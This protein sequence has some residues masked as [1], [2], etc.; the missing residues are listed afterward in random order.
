MKTPRVLI[1]D[2]DLALQGLM[3]RRIQQMGLETDKA[4][5]GQQAVD[6]I[7]TLDFDLIVTDINMPGASGLEILS[8]AKQKDP[9]VQVII[10]TG[11]A[12]LGTAVEALNKGAFGY[13]TKPFDHLSVLENTAAR[14]LAFRHLTLDNLRMAETQRRRGN[15]LEEEVAE[16]LKQ[17]GRQDREMRQIMTHLPEGILIV[18]R[19]GIIPSNPRG[20][21]WM[22]DDAASADHPLRAYVEEVRAGSASERRL[23]VLGDTT[24]EATA[25]S[26]SND[27][28][29]PSRV[30]IL[31]D[32]SE[33]GRALGA[34]LVGPLAGLAQGLAAL[35][36]RRPEA[37]EREIILH[38]ARSLQA[39]SAM[40]A[41]CARG[42][43]P[44]LAPA[45]L[46]EPRS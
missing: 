45:H 40:Q 39:L 11:D 42:Q 10:V 43:G 3:L 26:L 13:L 2:D 27:N 32:L 25:L 46:P 36:A 17:V 15:L 28:S 5:D 9:Y 21:K 1:S 6:L 33:E 23:M 38:M 30:I 18:G 34:E 44:A 24:V 31:R 19:R 29:R 35:L 37:Q 8:L 14:A 7:Q 22:D 4:S 12:S 41:A 16:R 20:R